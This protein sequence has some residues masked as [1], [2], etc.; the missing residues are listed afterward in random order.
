LNLKGR[1]KD[2]E[3]YCIMM[4][5]ITCNSTPNFVRVIKSR[6]MRWAG[7][8]VFIGFWL[9]GPKGREHWEDLDVGG[10]ITLS[11]TIRR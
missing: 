3:E 1:K 7:H 6:R 8:E 10:R 9:G 5:F 2:H 11:W 4:N